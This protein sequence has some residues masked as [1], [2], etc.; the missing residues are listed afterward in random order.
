M[1]A[2]PSNPIPTP[3]TTLGASS[4]A[5]S[6][7]PGVPDGSSGK[8]YQ[9]GSNS[10]TK[11]TAGK[12]LGMVSETSR[13]LIRV[14]SHDE[15]L[16]NEKTAK[17]LSH[18]SIESLN[19]LAGLLRD[20]FE[21]AVRHRRM[22]GIDE[23]FIRDMRAYN[24]QYDPKKLQEINAFGGSAVY[25]R[26]MTMKCRGATALLRNVYMN[27]D[28][29]WT[30]DPTPDPQIRDSVDQNIK[31]LVMAEVASVNQMGQTVDQ[32]ALADRMEGLYDAAKL[33]ER[34]KAI[35]EA[36]EAQRK[37]DDMLDQGNFYQALTDFLVD[38]PIYKHAIIKGPT[39]RRT[40]TLKWAK[41]KPVAHEEARFYWDRVSPWDVWFTPGATAITNTDVFERQRLSVQ[42]L[43]AMLGLPGYRDTDIRQIIDTYDKKGFQE[44]I[45]LFEYER[46]YMEGRNNVLDDTFINAIEFHGFVLGKYLKEFNIPGCDDDERP[47]FV[48]AWMVD[49]RIFKVM[50]NPSPRQRVPYYVTSFDKTPG[51]ISGNGIPALANDITDVM[52]ATLRA[53]VNNVSISSGPQVMIDRDLIGPSQDDNLYPWKRWSYISDPANPNRKP[54]DF[55]QPTSNAQELLGVFD[56]FSVMLDDVSTIPRYLTGGGANSG[57]GRTASGLSM[58]INNANKTLQNVADNIDNDIMRPLL[59]QLYDY[60]ML[61]DDTGMLRGD[62]NISVEGVRQASTQEQD[63]TRQLEF[64]QLINNPTYQ[65]L[66]PPGEVARILQKISDSLGMEV[67]IM[68]P[69]DPI[70]KPNAMN[71]PVPPSPVGGQGGPNPSGDQTPGPNPAAAAPGAGG[72]PGVQ[73]APMV[74][75]FN[76]VSSNLPHG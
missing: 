75:P 76:N 29:A 74:V 69:D 9:T 51:S 1:A 55:F 7:V 62:E 23:E 38:L 25:T 49:K 39:T 50:M 56:K 61:T 52:N 12:T 48:T 33:A 4:R 2:I 64:L 16:A 37:I 59:T 43:Y 36:A 45:Q 20:R 18:L 17:D 34:R 44:W 63:L 31:K 71:P 73:P 58:L 22:V 68:Q 19:P 67:K 5:A 60:I 35:T 46:A 27:S 11:K 53:L 42:D 10:Q 57:A 21:K 65:S 28:R 3:S 40:T 30:L 26:M 24:G 13:G 14:V 41:N 47:Y 15:M 72:V 54:V 66:I 8:K 32:N 70:N 6:P